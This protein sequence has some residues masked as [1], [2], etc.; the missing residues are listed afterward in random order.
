VDKITSS[1]VFEDLASLSLLKH[2]DH[3]FKSAMWEY[4]MLVSLSAYWEWRMKLLAE[5][6][7][8]ST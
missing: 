5:R 4:S 8:V 1:L 3:Y 2:Q 6:F 7:D